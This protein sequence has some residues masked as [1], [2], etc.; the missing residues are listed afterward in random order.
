[1]CKL[2]I[3]T[4][5]LRDLKGI[6]LSEEKLMLKGYNWSDYIKYDSIDITLLK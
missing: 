4:A 3:A 2:L 6:I 5:T 1:M